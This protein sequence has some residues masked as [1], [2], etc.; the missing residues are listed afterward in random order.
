MPYYT[1]SLQNGGSTYRVQSARRNRKGRVQVTV[2]SRKKRVA[3]TTQID[4]S[5]RRK[6]HE[7]VAQGETR[8]TKTGGTGKAQGVG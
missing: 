8:R 3:N 7:R 5:V 2:Q 6:G 4:Q 1:V